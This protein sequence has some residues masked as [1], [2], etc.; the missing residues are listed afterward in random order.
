MKRAANRRSRRAP[1]AKRN[2]LARVRS[3]MPALTLPPRFLH[4]HPVP[5]LGFGVHAH[6]RVIRNLVLHFPTG[7][8][9]DVV[10]G[11]IYGRGGNRIG[12]RRAGD[13]VRLPGVEGTP[14]TLYAHRLVWECVNGPIPEGHYIDHKNTIK[15]DNRCRNLQAVTP[16]RNAALVFERGYG[17]HGEAKSNSKLTEER[18]RLI[19]SAWG[20]KLTNGELGALF[21]VHHT[22]VRDARK[23]KTWKRVKRRS[24]RAPELRQD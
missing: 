14:Q 9:V 19:R 8:T 10:M 20:R 17:Q 1:V 12:T 7:Y 16:S 22:T 6:S 3:A 18:V 13:Y 15:D 11:H 2:R 24:S 5:A 4:P 21:G 23:R